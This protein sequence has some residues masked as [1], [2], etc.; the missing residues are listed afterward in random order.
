[1]QAAVFID[2][3][4]L[5]YAASNGK[6]DPEKTRISREL[7][8]G[9]LWVVSMQV[10]QEFHVN[11]TKKAALGIGSQKA[12][13]VLD[14]LLG[15]AVVGMDRELFTG[16]VVLQNRYCLS[17]WDAAVLGAAK[18]ANCRVVFSEDMDSG[19]LYDG[20]LVLNPFE[21]GGRWLREDHPK[22]GRTE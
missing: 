19:G 21:Q 10:V 13:A 9:R 2:T 16:A 22:L 3:N 8:R 7:L 1:M 5:L 11:A 14:E 12:G 15:R 6:S 18:R 4:V 20:T 17:Y